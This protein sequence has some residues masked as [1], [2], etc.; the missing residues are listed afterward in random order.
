MRMG[1][2]VDATCDLPQEFI[3]EKG[4]RVLPIHIRLGDEKVMDQRDPD[5]TLHFYNEHLAERGMDA[6]TSPYSADEVRE[7]FLRD[8]VLDFD[9][10][11][12]ITVTSTRSPI[13]ENAQK[14]SFQILNEYKAIRE[15]KQVPGLFTMRVLDSQTLFSGTAVLAAHAADLIEQN[16]APNQIRKQLEDLRN[17]ISAYM[18]PSDLYYIRTRAKKK[19]DSSVGLMTYAIGSALDIKPVLHAYRGE[20]KPVAKVRHYEAAV[21]QLMAYTCRRIADGLR[22]PTVCLSDGGDPTEIGKLPGYTELAATARQHGVQQRARQRRPDRAHALGP[23][24]RRAHALVHAH[25]LGHR[26]ESVDRAQERAPH[27]LG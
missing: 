15:Q 6:E 7:E 19:G 22:T 9:C 24:Q 25:R 16:L 21:E 26:R 2:V 27:L 13:Y 10:V 23:R 11:F 18:V 14:A 3:A 17:H 5:A 12:V 8:I 4:I 20:T 1:I